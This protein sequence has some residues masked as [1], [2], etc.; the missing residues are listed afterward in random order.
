M[1]AVGAWNHIAPHSTTT[2][3]LTWVVLLVLL[4]QHIY[5]LCTSVRTLA[6]IRSMGSTPW[7]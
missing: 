7:E 3:I 1:N 6:L 4:M 5:S 2:Y